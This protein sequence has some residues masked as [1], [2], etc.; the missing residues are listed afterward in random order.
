MAQKRTRKWI[1]KAIKRPGALR[2]KAERAG[3]TIEEFCRPI[4]ARGKKT[5]TFLQ[6]NLALRVLKKVR[7][8][9]R[10]KK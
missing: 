10:K 3:K 8:K 1:Q 5:R 4:L 6:C 9:G 2:A 7:P